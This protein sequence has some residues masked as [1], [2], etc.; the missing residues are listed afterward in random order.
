MDITQIP[1]G[2]LLDVEG[3][4]LDFTSFREFG[5][6]IDSEFNNIRNYHG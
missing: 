6:D 2:K 1:T 4:A 3:T 5:K